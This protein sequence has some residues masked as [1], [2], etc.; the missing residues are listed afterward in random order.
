MEPYRK[1]LAFLVD[2]SAKG[3]GPNP[4]SER[5]CNFFVEVKCIAFLKFL[6]SNYYKS[7]KASEGDGVKGLSGHVR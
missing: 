1:K 7:I 4:L 3:R 5:K 2:M 6:N